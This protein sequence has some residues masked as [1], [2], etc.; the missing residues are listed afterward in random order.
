MTKYY[1]YDVMDIKIPTS[2]RI[3]LRVKMESKFKGGETV[4]INTAKPFQNS[5]KTQNFNNLQ[6]NNNIGRFRWQK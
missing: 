2:C 6:P 5:E 4:L 1:S 3:T